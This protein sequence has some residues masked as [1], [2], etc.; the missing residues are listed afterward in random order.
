MVG[1]GPNNTNGEAPS[2]IRVIE[3]LK[4]SVERI[5]TLPLSDVT[6]HIKSVATPAAIPFAAS[7]SSICF[8]VRVSVVAVPA[9]SDGISRAGASRVPRSLEQ[10]STYK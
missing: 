6:L 5:F 7:A 1:T 8:W 9:T 2:F 10:Q 3:I 4:T